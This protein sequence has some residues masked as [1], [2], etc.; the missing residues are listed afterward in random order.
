MDAT[1]HTKH[2]LLT[3]LPPSVCATKADGISSPTPPAA[4]GP[5]S[6]GLPAA[7]RAAPADATV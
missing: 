1:T 5:P 7:G 2:K 6:G 3:R 4:G